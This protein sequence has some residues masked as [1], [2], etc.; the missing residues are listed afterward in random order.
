MEFNFLGNYFQGKFQQPPT[1]G[2]GQVE[3]FIEKNSPANTQVQLWRYPIDYRHIEPTIDSLI[4]GCHQLKKIKL[5][6]RLQLIEK[7]KDE[8]S[9]EKQTLAHILSLETGR[10]LWDTSEEIE[11]TILNLQNIIEL[12]KVFVEQFIT[13]KHEH[14]FFKS[15]GPALIIGSASDPFALT[16]EQICYLFITGNSIIYKPSEEVLASSQHLFTIFHRLNFPIGS[17]N[18]LLGDKEMALRLIKIKKIKN[19]FFAGTTDHGLEVAKLYGT[20]LQGQLNLQLSTKNI[21]VIDENTD[22]DIILPALT[23]AAYQSAGQL[24]TKTSLVFIHENIA[25]KFIENFHQLAKKIIIDHP[26]NKEPTPFMGPLMNK[27]KLDN[28]LQYMGMAIRENAQEVMRGKQLQFEDRPGYYVT[29]SI[30]LYSDIPAEIG[31]FLKD[32]QLLPNITFIK[33]KEL[34]DI[35]SFTRKLPFGLLCSIFT[36]SKENMRYLTHNLE[37][38]IIL[39]NAFLTPH[40]RNFRFGGDKNSSNFSNI[41]SAMLEAGLKRVS[42]QQDKNITTTSELVGINN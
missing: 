3:I 20:N 28:Y 9:Q 31:H 33:F 10:P 35:I 37:V 6:H 17:V 39:Q 8:I 30:H 40:R 24:S 12:S 32:E 15:A 13:K 25:D 42:I 11:Q 19:I 29:P 26:L 41:G 22:S 1:S 16:L 27:T 4:E 7:L 34:K 2:L 36:K 5:N 18:L 14:F 38:G 21:A 23:K